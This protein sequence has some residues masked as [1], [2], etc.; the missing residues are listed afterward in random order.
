MRELSLS[1]VECVIC[2][3]CRLCWGVWYSECDLIKFIVGSEQLFSVVWSFALLGNGRLV[4]NA[5]GADYFRLNVQ[6]ES[7]SFGLS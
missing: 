7:S 3:P 4:M 1:S 2:L 6:K 5:V